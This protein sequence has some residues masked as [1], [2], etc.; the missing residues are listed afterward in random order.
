MPSFFERLRRFMN[1][2][3][4]FQ[5][6]EETDD[7]MRAKEKDDWDMPPQ[8]QPPVQH[9]STSGTQTVAPETPPQLDPHSIVAVIERVENRINGPNLDISLT[10]R[11]NAP[12]PVTLDKILWFG[13]TYELDWTL[14]PG[15][16]REFVNVYSGPR[17]TNGNYT[18]CELQYF[19]QDTN[20]QNNYL[21]A[22]HNL[23]F[24]QEADKTY[25][26]H[27][28]RFIPPVKDV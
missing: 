4:V 18:H 19:F 7:P 9:T 20:G 22:I 28:T 3:P 6:G 5:P 8:T 27:R 17:P 15:Q 10:V 25:T 11:N 23:E 26:V 21:S 14:N 16:E 24:Q 13:Q 1:G 2:Q 12:V